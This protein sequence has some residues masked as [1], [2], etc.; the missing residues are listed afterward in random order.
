[1]IPSASPRRIVDGPL[2]YTCY[3]ARGPEP[4]S[5]PYVFTDRHSEQFGFRNPA[6]DRL[7]ARGNTATNQQAR[8][9]QAAGDPLPARSLPMPSTFFRPPVRN[10]VDIFGRDS[11]IAPGF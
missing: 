6:S 3:P 10:P 1:M 5:T 11:P 9:A 4:R 8:R 7:K 2:S